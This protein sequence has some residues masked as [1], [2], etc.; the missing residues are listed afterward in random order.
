MRKGKFLFLTLL[1][2]AISFAAGGQGFSQAPANVEIVTGAISQNTTWTA[3]NVYVLRGAVFV[4]AGAT[5]TIEPGTL[6]AGEFATNGTLVVAQGG[7]LNAVGTAAQPIVFTSDQPYGPPDWPSDDRYRADWGGLVI[8]GFGIINIP[9]GIGFGEGGT[10]QYGGNNNND[11]SGALRYVR[12][13]YAGTEFSPDNELNGIA[14]QGTG[15][16]TAV[17]FIQV[18]MNL[19]DGIEMFGGATNIRHF[20][21]TNIGDDSLDYTDGWV[22]KAQFGVIQQRADDADQGFEFDNNGENNDLLPRSNP[23]IYNV[24]LIG[25]NTSVWGSESDHGMLIRE[26][27]AGRIV[28]CIVLDFREDGIR[29]DQSATVTQAEQGNLVLSSIIVFGNGNNFDSDT[30]SILDQGLW[31][32]VRVINPQI[33]TPHNWVNPDFRP[34]MTSPAV[35]GTVP[36]APIPAGDPFFVQTAFIGAMGPLATD[37]WTKTPVRWTTGAQGF[38]N[39]LPGQGIGVNG[40]VLPNSIDPDDLLLVPGAPGAPVGGVSPVGPS[41]GDGDGG[42]GDGPEEIGPGWPGCCN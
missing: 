26:G 33:R 3:N 25:D 42:G 15:R 21:L 23:T 36:V 34:T 5:L 24:T 11:S 22:G 27:T 32:N 14:F 41:G 1:V 31:P 30:Q 19:D 35:T 20:V 9:G 4:T 17:E 39:F 7:T 6:I 29:V 37:D 38:T 12:V 10:G 2:L 40:R 16:G 18:H 13:E 8:N 28:N